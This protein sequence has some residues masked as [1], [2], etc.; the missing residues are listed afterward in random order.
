LCGEPGRKAFPAHLS[1][2]D[3]RSAYCLY[4][5]GRKFSSDGGKRKIAPDLSFAYTRYGLKEMGCNRQTIV[6]ENVWTVF[7]LHL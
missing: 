4:R 1:I 6:L 2:M 5:S 7:A 3:D